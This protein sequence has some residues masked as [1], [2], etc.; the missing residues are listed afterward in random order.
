MSNAVL[1]LAEAIKEKGRRST[2]ELPPL[3]EQAEQL[4]RN[5]KLDPLSRALAYRAAGNALHL[6]NN[7]QLALTNYDFAISIL[8]TLTAPMNSDAPCIQR[9]VCSCS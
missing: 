8:E 7:F 2:H 6:L 3:L 1:E 4:A 5:E 9:S